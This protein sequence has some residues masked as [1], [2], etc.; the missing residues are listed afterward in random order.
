[1]KVGD[2]FTLRSGPIASLFYTGPSGRI[3]LGDNV[4]FNSGLELYASELVEIDD[5]VMVGSNVTIY[6]TNFHPLEEVAETKRGPVRIGY[7]AWL[8][9]GATILPGVT[10]GAQ[11]VVGAGSVISRDVPPRTLVAGNPAVVVRELTS[12]ESWNR[13]PRPGLEGG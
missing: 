8:A 10:I 2:H 11:S 4:G 13:W 12:S 6:D 9:R 3:L 7:N 1:M 5:Y